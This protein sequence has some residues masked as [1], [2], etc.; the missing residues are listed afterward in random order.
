MSTTR[1]FLA[2]CTTMAAAL[3]AVFLLTAAKDGP[4][5][6][7]FDEITVGRINIVEPDGTKRI[8]I[9]NRAQFP[10]AF[11]QGKEIARPDRRDFAGMLFLDEEGNEN[12]GFIQKGS[13]SADGKISAGLSLTFDRYRQDQAMQIKHINDEKQGSSSLT[14]NDV[15]HYSLTPIDEYHTL[16]KQANALPE[17]ERMAFW[18]KLAEE[19]KLS[20]PRIKLGTTPRKDSILLL[21]DAKGRARMR[22]MVSASGNAAIEML[23]ETGKVVKTISPDK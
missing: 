22:L 4:S 18:N 2:G 8:I 9:S 21:N 1:T 10:G 20:Q 13:M 16:Y 17:S 12:G 5:R 3:S 14:F 6:A 7:N 19:G 23:D 15:P 11:T